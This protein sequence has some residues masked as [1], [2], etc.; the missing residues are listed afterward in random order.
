LPIF[1][2]HLLKPSETLDHDNAFLKTIVNIDSQSKNVNGVNKV[3]TIISQVLKKSGFQNLLLDNP[4]QE[5]GKLLT[6]FYKGKSKKVYTLICHAD[7]AL[8]LN[9]KN[10]FNYDPKRKIATG[11]GIADNKAG[12]M[13]AIRGALD[14]LRQNPNPNIS[15]RLVC[16]PNEEL[17][18]P[19]FQN[20]LQQFGQSSHTILGFEPA[21]NEKDLIHSRNGNRWYQI[22]TKGQSFHSG[23]APS[24]H[25]NA[26]YELSMKIKKIYDLNF[27]ISDGSLS[28]S[29]CLR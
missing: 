23:R 5:S 26:A 14:F 20:L 22:K 24:I 13:I 27:K 4:S 3:Q 11:T 1:V 6:A 2:R 17:G 9:P 8:K 29:Q 19:G 16:S 25:L 7:T 18:S 10:K 21:L 12:V 15:I 28:V